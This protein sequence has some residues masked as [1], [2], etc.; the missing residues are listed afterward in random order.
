[1]ARVVQRQFPY[2]EC[3]EPLVLHPRARVAG[4]PDLLRRDGA[5]LR[6][7]APAARRPDQCHPRRAG[8]GRA[9]RSS[10]QGTRSGQTRD[11]AIWDFRPALLSG[12][13]GRIGQ[14][15]SP[16]FPSDP[17]ADASDAVPDLVRRNSGGSAGGSAGFRGG[18][19]EGFPDRRGDS[20]CLSDRAVDAGLLHRAATAD[21]A[22]GAAAPV[23]GRRL[24]RGLLGTPALSVPARA[25]AGL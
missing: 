21:C 7:G 24:R 13:L 19:E 11:R 6:D 2:L 15:E 10:Q 4:D 14:P 8:D 1:M 20:R 16:G 5:G 17:R 23:S 22:G 18:A 9:D 25:D 12:R 3:D